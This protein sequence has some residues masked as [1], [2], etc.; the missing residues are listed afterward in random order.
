MLFMFILGLIEVFRLLIKDQILEV[1]DL[2]E[3]KANEKENKY[4]NI[5]KV[6][7]YFFIDNKIIDPNSEGVRY[8]MK[9][10]E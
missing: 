2:A 6:R 4:K 1:I 5:Q 10:L 3:K 9:C 7:R 8:V